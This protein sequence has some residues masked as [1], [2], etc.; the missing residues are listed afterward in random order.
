MSGKGK[1]V[2]IVEDETAIGNALRLKLEHE[3]I[4]VHLTSNGREALEWVQNNP[5]DLVILDLIMPEMDGFG[6][7]QAVK[8][9]NLD[10]KVIVISNLSQAE[11]VEKAKALGALDFMVKSNTALKEIVEKIHTHLK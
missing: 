4:D 11:D 6:F 10:L 9:K 5:V 1:K 2:L 8:E 7:L 3:K